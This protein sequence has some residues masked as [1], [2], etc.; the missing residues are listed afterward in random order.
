MSVAEFK[1][2]VADR[3]PHCKAV[4]REPLSVLFQ[5]DEY[6]LDGV[7]GLGFHGGHDDGVEEAG[8]S[9]KDADEEGLFAGKRVVQRPRVDPRFPQDRG[10]TCRVKPLLVEEPRGGLEDAVLRVDGANPAVL[11]ERSFKT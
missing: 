10:D 3:T 5:E 4:G 1:G 2:E 8:V 7:L 9:L 11:I 6:A